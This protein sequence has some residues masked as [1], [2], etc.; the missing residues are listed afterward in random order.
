MTLCEVCQELDNPPLY[1]PAQRGACPA[2]TAAFMWNVAN[3]KAPEGQAH[4]GVLLSSLD[5]SRLFHGN[6]G[7]G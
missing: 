2:T 6:L 5:V 1:I 3:T 4:R 7:M